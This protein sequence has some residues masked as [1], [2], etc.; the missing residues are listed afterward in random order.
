MK[1]AGPFAMATLLVLSTC[2]ALLAKEGLSEL[3]ERE[4]CREVLGGSGEQTVPC[5]LSAREDPE[6]LTQR[7][8]APRG[9]G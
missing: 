1:L 9:D 8:A 2:A 5:S 3:T 4:R 7:L 6:P